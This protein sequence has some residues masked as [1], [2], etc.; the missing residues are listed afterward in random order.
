MFFDANVNSK[1]KISFSSSCP[2]IKAIDSLS[3]LMKC[4][5]AHVRTAL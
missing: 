5:K 4:L 3:L 1:F 2:T